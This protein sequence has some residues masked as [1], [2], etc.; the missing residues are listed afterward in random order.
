MSLNPMEREIAT[1]SLALIGGSARLSRA[2]YELVASLEMSSLER[3][4]IQ[5]IVAETRRGGN[6][7]GDRLR[8]ARGMTECGLPPEIAAAMTQW[9][10]RKVEPSRIVDTCAKT[11]DLLRSV[12]RTFQQSS[13][14]AIEN[15]A[16]TALVLRANITILGM[17]RRTRIVVSGE[18]IAALPRSLGRVEYLGCTVNRAGHRETPG[19]H[20]LEAASG[21]V[22]A[23][24]TGVFLVPAEWLDST[25]ASAS[26]RLLVEKLGVT[27]I[28]FMEPRSAN[29]KMIAAIG[30]RCGDPSSTVGMRFARIP[31]DVTAMNFEIG[32]KVSREWL[33]HAACWTEFANP[34]NPQAKKA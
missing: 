7:L 30:I 22:R 33:R 9:I 20:M 31:V 6:P 19:F 15:D 17:H 4:A 13:L 28:H 25:E 24:D 10:T 23:G 14:V 2:E 27:N 8:S 34:E 12:A 26:R 1:L 18:D 5:E 11:G 16:L 21:L 29:E 3:D 32:V